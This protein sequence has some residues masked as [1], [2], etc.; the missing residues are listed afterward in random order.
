MAC[1]GRDYVGI[2]YATQLIGTANF[3]NLCRTVEKKTE[4]KRGQALHN[5]TRS[6]QPH[7][8]PR[9]SGVRYVPS[10]RVRPGLRAEPDEERASLVIRYARQSSVASNA[11]MADGDAPKPQGEV[12]R[13]SEKTG[14]ERDPQ[15]SPRV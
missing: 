10:S 6:P 7:A 5:A 1:P 3:S 11:G 9:L 12:R 14:T 4:E 13:A 15:A 2:G 8:R